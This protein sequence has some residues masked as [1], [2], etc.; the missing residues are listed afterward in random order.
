MP[1]ITVEDSATVNWDRQTDVIVVGYGGAG[2]AAALEARA[3]DAVVI[4]IDRFGGG[5]TTAYSGGVFYAGGT[6]FQRE[7]GYHDDSDNLYRYLEL[8]VRDAVRSETLRRFCE[9]SA[10]DVEW[11]VR[12]GVEYSSESYEGKITFPPEGK[13]L[14]YSG[15]EKTPAYAAKARPVPRGHRAVGAGY[16]GP[17]FF[18]ALSRAVDRN[19]AEVIRHARVTRLVAD[20]SG[21]VLG[22]EALA[23]PAAKHEEHQRAYEKVSPWVPHHNRA[24]DRALAE[25]S[26]L[27]E[28]YGERILIRARGG[29]VLAT[30]GY[31][32]NRELLTKYTPEFARHYDKVHRLACIGSTGSGVEFAESVGGGVG[33]MDSLYIARNIAPPAALLDGIIVNLAGQR[34]V[35]EDAYTAVVGGQIAKQP[36]AVAWLIVPAKS[37]TRAIREA[38][39]C[40]WHSFKFFGLPTLANILLGGT[41]RGAT[42]AKLACKAGIDPAGLVET[43]V[44]FDSDI[45]EGEPDRV[46]RADNLRVPLGNGPFYALNV[47]ISNAHAFTPFMTLGGITVNEDNGQVT[48]ADGSD[49][50]G[51]YAAGLCAVGLNSC[52]YISGMSL[53][54]GVFTGR[55]AGQDAAMA[56][57]LASANGASVGSEAA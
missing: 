42:A 53:S 2:A 37:F 8:E 27:E 16:G 10:G 51:L 56:A 13:Y 47:S 34:F 50:E 44:A 19:G 30:G 21:R 3:N 12:H 25:M 24:K 23:L 46:G 43:I 36:D 26:A 28:R 48:R 5:G 40:G 6:R 38:L 32:F 35:A 49:I 54:D 39:S 20:K 31:S 7:A 17:H 41:K 33:R 57:R 4:V 9:G 14:Y 45:V 1:P 29:V 22:V 55:R 15:N 52:G 18:A 11:L